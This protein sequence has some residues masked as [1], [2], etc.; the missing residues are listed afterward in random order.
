MERRKRKCEIRLRLYLGFRGVF[1]ADQNLFY[2][3]HIFFA[4]N[5]LLPD[6][7]ALSLSLTQLFI[8]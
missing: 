6:T 2:L 4:S 1:E 3:L 8:R 7:H 5:R